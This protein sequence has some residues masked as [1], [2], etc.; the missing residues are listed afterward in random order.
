MF[1]WLFSQMPPK[2]FKL[3]NEEDPQPSK[4]TP[5]SLTNA[6]YCEIFEAVI[7]IQ[8]TSP[9]CLDLKS[10]LVGISPQVDAFSP[11]E[12]AS[13]ENSQKSNSEKP[14]VDEPIQQ[15]KI[16]KTSTELVVSSNKPKQVHSENSNQSESIST[17]Y[18]EDFRK[19]AIFST[20]EV[21]EP[22]VKKKQKS[23]REAVRNLKETESQ[24]SESLLASLSQAQTSLSSSFLVDGPLSQPPAHLNHRERL[25]WLQAR[26]GEN[27]LVQCD[28]CDKWRLS[29]VQD[30]VD[31][32]SFWYCYM[33]TG[34][35]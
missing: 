6:E 22:T 16:Q 27:V 10:P 32:P 26:R 5:T 2:K 3:P 29:D 23:F 21:K 33:N 35:F 15:E 17:V 18:S 14:I 25:L 4:S 13:L 19:N 1:L 8:E 30:P 31:L 7:K 12:C 28:T 34:N 9:Q 11:K 20:P 24:L